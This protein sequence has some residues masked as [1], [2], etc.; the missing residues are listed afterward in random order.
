[1]ESGRCRTQIDDFD[2]PVPRVVPPGP[3]DG[4]ILA[5]PDL[6]QPPSIHVAGNELAL[7][8]AG[9]PQRQVPVIWTAADAV[10]MAHHGKGKSPQRR[11]AQ[12]GSQ[13]G[14]LVSRR[15]GQ[16]VRIELELNCRQAHPRRGGRRRADGGTDSPIS[17][18]T[19]L[20]G[21]IVPAHNG[22]VAIRERRGRG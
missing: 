17:G 2:T 22:V 18:G 3:R 8:G 14:N 7:Y 6:D 13:L 5:Q 10:G 1:M 9:T 15:P 21:D 12:R 4:I 16:P 20:L 19:Q 11:K